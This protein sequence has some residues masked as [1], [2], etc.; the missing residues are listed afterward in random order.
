LSAARMTST[1]ELTRPRTMTGPSTLQP[2][3]R[4]LR[5]ADT[6]T[7]R[8]VNGRPAPFFPPVDQRLLPYRRSPRDTDH[9]PSHRRGMSPAR[10]SP[11]RRGVGRRVAI[12]VV[13]LF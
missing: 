4:V 6:N 5:L 3:Q 12:K 2:A 11:R 8:Q 13:S 9:G 7:R 10:S 1:Y